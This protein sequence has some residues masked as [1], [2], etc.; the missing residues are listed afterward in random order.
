[1][2]DGRSDEEHF[3]E[4][5]AELIKELADA[6]FIVL[7]KKGDWKEDLKDVRDHI[8]EEMVDVRKTL[9]RVLE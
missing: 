7:K 5:C 8:L 1:M 6:Q 9:R 3:I 4:E 2:G